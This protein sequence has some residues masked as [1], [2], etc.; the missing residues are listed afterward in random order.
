MKF[1]TGFGLFPKSEWR[2]SD[3]KI[4]GSLERQTEL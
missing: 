3:L 1:G 2:F 4:L